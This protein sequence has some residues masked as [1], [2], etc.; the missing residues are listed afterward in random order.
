MTRLPIIQL[1]DASGAPYD[2]RAAGDP[3]TYRDLATP[4][5]LRRIATYA[6]GVGPHKDLVLPLDASGNTTTPSSLVRDAHRRRLV[7]HVFTLRR[8]NRFMAQNFRRGAD[9]NAAGDLAAEVRAFLGAG[10]DGL[11]TDH[12]DL[13]VEARDGDTRTAA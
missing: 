10:V 3:R 2:L 4:E 5:G 1:L 6:D 12:P 13:A 7:V 8:E 9:P 11:F